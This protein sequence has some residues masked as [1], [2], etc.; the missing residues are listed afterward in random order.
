MQVLVA[1]DIAARG[2]DINELP[3]VVNFDLPNVPEDYVHRIGRTGRASAAGEAVSL[4]CIDEYKLLA[5]IEKLIKRQLPKEVI[6]GFQPEPHAKPETIQNGFQGGQIH[7]RNQQSPRFTAEPSSSSA[8][9]KPV[10]TRT[11]G[12]KS[13]GRR[14]PAGIRAE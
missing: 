14:G 4:V 2:I 9:S 10:L 12:G 13:G 6:G 8:K 1:T 3:Q 5:D 7:D 11:S